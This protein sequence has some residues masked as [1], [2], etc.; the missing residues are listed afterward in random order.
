MQ[1]WRL[2]FLPSF[3]LGLTA[4]GAVGRIWKWKKMKQYLTILLQTGLNI[5][6]LSD[7][8]LSLASNLKSRLLLD[9]VLKCN[10]GKKLTTTNKKNI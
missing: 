8:A 7:T 6:F 3:K 10:L 4:S 2:F 1:V 5:F 9:F